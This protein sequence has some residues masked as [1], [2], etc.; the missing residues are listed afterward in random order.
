MTKS[1][2]FSH[3]AI[4]YKEAINIHKHNKDSK[5]QEMREDENEKE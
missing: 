2:A 5:R 3:K 1:S 4:I